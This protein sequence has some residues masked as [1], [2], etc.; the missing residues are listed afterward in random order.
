M[1]AAENA[2]IEE[3]VAGTKPPKKSTAKTTTGV[4]RNQVEP[5]G[6]RA[7]IKRAKATKTEN[8]TPID[9]ATH[10]DIGVVCGEIANLFV[11]LSKTVF[12]EMSNG[13]TTEPQSAYDERLEIVAIMLRKHAD[14][15]DDAFALHLVS[16]IAEQFELAC[17]AASPD[18]GSPKSQGGEQRMNDTNRVVAELR[19]PVG[20]VV[21]TGDEKHPIRFELLASHKQYEATLNQEIGAALL[22]GNG[23]IVSLMSENDTLDP[24]AMD[25]AAEAVQHVTSGNIEMVAPSS[26]A[27]DE[28]RAA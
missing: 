2:T 22:C 27:R 28:M 3:K 13:N 4:V 24:V 19:G 11:R 7:P 6:N 15:I 20:R 9:P 10:D 14:V 5:N 12:G 1:A 17:Q 18:N 16:L 8:L 25:C 21:L 23:E 26:S